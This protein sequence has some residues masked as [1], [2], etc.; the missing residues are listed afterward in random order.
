MNIGLPMHGCWKYQN[1]ISRVFFLDYFHLLHFQM[2]AGGCLDIV[3]IYLIAHHT[4]YSTQLEFTACSV[5][6]M[7]I[8]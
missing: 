6:H 5:V 3:D 7:Y 8:L 4:T 1:E 2:G